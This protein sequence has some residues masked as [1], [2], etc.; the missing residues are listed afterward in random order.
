MPCLCGPLAHGT[1]VTR[2]AASIPLGMVRSVRETS[3]RQGHVKYAGLQ[4]GTIHKYNL[5][6]NRFFVWLSSAE[7]SLPVSLDELDEA[8]GE[9]INHLYQDDLP[10]GWASDVVCGF[11]RFYPKCRKSLQISGGYLRNWNKKGV[12]DT[13]S[14]F[15]V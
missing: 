10:V 3:T 15:N 11:Q 2:G 7:Q 9:Y 14:P 5:A 8:I 4:L 12:Q 1:S 6:I 13:G